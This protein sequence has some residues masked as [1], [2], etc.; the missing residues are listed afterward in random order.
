MSDSQDP[1]VTRLLRDLTRELQVLRRELDSDRRRG[2]RRRQLSRFTSEVAIPSVILVLE[3]N[4]RALKLLRRAIRLAEGR[5]PR[6]RRGTREDIQDRAEQLGSEALSR[7]DQTLATVQSS[8]EE[9]SADEEV[10][11][12]ID[13]ARQLQSQISQQLDTERTVDEAQQPT[14]R[15]APSDPVAIDVDTELQTLKDNLD[16]GADENADDTPPGDDSGEP[17]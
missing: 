7:L 3:T 5:E 16:D 8:L 11:Q 1:D 13:E 12:L 14:D 17:P 15:E 6:E 9:G 10:G 4:I 2:S